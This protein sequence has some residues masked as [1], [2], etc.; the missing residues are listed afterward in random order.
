MVTINITRDT[1]TP[2][3][4]QMLD[5]VSGRRGHAVMG[6]AVRVLVRDHLRSKEAQP[7]KRGWPKTHFYARARERVTFAATETQC[8][9]SIAM[10]GM[11]QRYHGGR[12]A[13]VNRKALTIPLVPE[14]YGKMAGE[15]G[16]ALQFRPAYGGNVVGFLEGREG[17]PLE[18]QAVFL[19]VRSVVQPPDPSVIPTP[20]AMVNAAAQALAKAVE[21]DRR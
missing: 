17:S 13:P 11:R 3:I 2:A 9:V 12:I 19:L 15:F 20:T 21:R 6:Q 1:A 5:Q 18:G 8:T 10:E 16:S 7:N 14:A 4:R